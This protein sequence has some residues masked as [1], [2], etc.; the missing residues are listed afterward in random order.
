LGEFLAIIGLYTV[1]RYRKPALGQHVYAT[2]FDT[3]GPFE[4]LKDLESTIEG[5][6]RVSLG[7]LD[8]TNYL[9][10]AVNVVSCCGKHIGTVY[11]VQDSKF[12]ALSAK[13]WDYLMN[14]H[15]KQRLASGLDLNTGRASENYQLIL[16]H[17]WPSI[18]ITPDLSTPG[19]QFVAQELVNNQ[20]WYQKA[21]KGFKQFCQNLFDK[22]P[23]TGSFRNHVGL[24]YGLAEMT[25]QLGGARVDDQSY[26]AFREHVNST[27]EFGDSVNRDPYN[28][29]TS[30]LYDSKTTTDAKRQTLLTSLRAQWEPVTLNQ[31]TLDPTQASALRHFPEP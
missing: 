10:G 2:T 30:A 1:A 21:T 12:P 17:S 14:S 8:V 20:S 22:Y 24:S 27:A 18:N 9:S 15:D 4:F 5:A 25:Y 31:Q 26:Q 23:S 28:L 13:P 7:T 16:M 3:P 29:D 11:S 6:D 19:L